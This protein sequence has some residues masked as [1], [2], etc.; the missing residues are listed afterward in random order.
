MLT[1]DLLAGRG[2]PQRYGTNFEMR[3]GEWK[4]TPIADEA[5]IDAL[6]NSVGLGSLKNYACVMRAMYGS[7]DQQTPNPAPSQQ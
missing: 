1:D 2:K 5:N 4:P 6:R 7:G 3:G